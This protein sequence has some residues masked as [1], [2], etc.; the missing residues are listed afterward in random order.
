MAAEITIH[1]RLDERPFIPLMVLGTTL[2]VA[3]VS[4]LT[5]KEVQRWQGC[6]IIAPEEPTLLHEMRLAKTEWV[7]PDGNVYRR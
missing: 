3:S 2:A 7:C 4:T 1:R 5:V 6:F